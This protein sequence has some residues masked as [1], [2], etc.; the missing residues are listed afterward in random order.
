[1]QTGPSSAR[2]SADVTIRPAT[3]SDLDAINAIY[4]HYVLHSTCTYQ[5]V[6]ESVEGRREWFVRHGPEHPVIVAELEGRVV[7]WGALSA[8]RT[9]TAYRHTVENSVYVEEGLRGRG[10]GTALLGR[11]LELAQ[12]LGH[13]AVIAVIDAE[14]APSLALHA[15]FGF[16]EVG[17]F[18]EIGHKFGRWLDVVYLELLLP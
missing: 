6:P 9:R 14:Q 1:M 7:G 18:R 16:Q 15:R 17:R 13:H 3:A 11:L 5:E 2:R 8:Y 4:N 10:I 12:A